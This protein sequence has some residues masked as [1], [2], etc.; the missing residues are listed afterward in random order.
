[1]KYI[2]TGSL[3]H[4]GKPLTETLIK[5]GNDVTVITSKR[6]HAS[7]IEALG[8]KAAVGSVD[9]VDFLTKTFTGAD[10]VYTMVPPKFDAT[11]VK[12]WHEQMGKNYAQAIK[13]ANIKYV[14]NLSS[15][16]AHMAEGAGPVSGLHRTEAALNTLSDV[17]IRHLRPAYFYH[18]L[19]ANI[20]LIKNMNIM[21]ANFEVQDKR[22]GIVHPNDI[23]AAAA[24]ELMRL[25]FKGHTVRYIA[26]DDVSTNEIAKTIGSAIGK[27]DLKW[28][29]FSDE[30]AFQGMKTAG[31]PEE[32]ANNYVE[33]GT[34]IHSGEMYSDYR[35]N[36]PQTLGKI[37][38]QDFAK[39]FAA[40]YNGTNS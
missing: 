33:M 34:A 38:L 37:K 15:I 32:V 28:V 6:E 35:K 27:P 22:F 39:E 13:A 5:A 30:Q 9:D 16:G 21:G 4:I 40:I 29:L 31:L 8:A 17:N 11:N 24:E 12:Q 19:L 18:N 20:G 26:S 7:K 23:A 10:A 14:V 1:M 2:I 25:D 36:H 3:G